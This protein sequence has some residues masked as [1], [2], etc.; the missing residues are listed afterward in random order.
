MSKTAKEIDFDQYAVYKTSFRASSAAGTIEA[1]LKIIAPSREMVV[2][3][4]IS[5]LEYF[6]ITSDTP[7]QITE[8]D[9]KAYEEEQLE[10]FILIK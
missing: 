1:K 4:V 2:E 9:P 8:T 6:N 7:L 10:E 3:W 5:E